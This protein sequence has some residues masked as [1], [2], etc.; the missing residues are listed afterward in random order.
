MILIVPADAN[1]GVSFTKK[2]HPVDPEIQRV[3]SRIKEI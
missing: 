3:L 1:R 2:P